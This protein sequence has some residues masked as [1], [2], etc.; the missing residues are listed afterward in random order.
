MWYYHWKWLAIGY[1]N[2]CDLPQQQDFVKIYI[3][4]YKNDKIL[5]LALGDGTGL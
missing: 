4:C 2:F 5:V 3:P 1:D